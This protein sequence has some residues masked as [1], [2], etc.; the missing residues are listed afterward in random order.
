V[1]SSLTEVGGKEKM[2]N[3]TSETK[4]EESTYDARPRVTI[5]TC[6]LSECSEMRAIVLYVAN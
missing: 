5:V 1:Q 3:R 4:N 2:R 6:Q